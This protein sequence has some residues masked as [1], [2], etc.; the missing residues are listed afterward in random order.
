M[1]TA[2]LMSVLIVAQ[3]PQPDRAFGGYR[4]QGLMEHS[5]M[6]NDRATV[7]ED[8]RR[9]KDMRLFWKDAHAS[10]RRA[11]YPALAG[12]Q[13][14]GGI[15]LALFGRNLSVFVDKQGVVTGI[16][17][18][19]AFDVPGF[20]K[21]RRGRHDRWA[22][23]DRVPLISFRIVNRTARPLVLV[24]SA[25]LVVGS[26]DANRTVALRRHGWKTWFSVAS[27][28]GERLAVLDTDDHR[29]ENPAVIA[30]P[31]VGASR[32]S[33]GWQVT[34][35]GDGSASGTADIGVT[36]TIRDK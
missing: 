23:S 27:R 12:K 20:I 34:R 30:T 13:L 4:F 19:S 16:S 25:G 15:G 31:T 9:R 10:F 1:P 8:A 7:R 32:L 5:V 17:G 6:P 22:S 24:D 35:Q 3:M 26:I 11:D 14:S 18:L 2:L 33:C 21:L 29:A 28:N 36:V